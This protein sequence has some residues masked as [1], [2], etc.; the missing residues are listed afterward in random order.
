MIKH[1][2]KLFITLLF[3]QATFAAAQEEAEEISSLPELKAA[4]TQLIADRDVPA[5]AIAMVDENGP[6]WVGAIGKANLQ[7]NI[8][9]DENTLFRIGSTSKMF[10]SLS[11]LKLVE[12][13]KLSLNDK[14]SALAPEI[15]YK[16]Q[17]ESTDPVRVVHLLE[18]TTG[19]DDIHLPEYAHNDPTPITLKQGLD[20][21]PHS[22]VSRWAPGSRMTYCNSG[23]AVAAY[24]VQKLTGRD[25]EEYVNESF[26]KPLGM[27]TATYVLSENVKTNGA[28]LYA[29]GNQPQDYWHILIRPSG[30]INASAKDMA[31]FLTFFIDRGAVSGR[32]LISTESLKRMETVESTSGAKVGLQSGYGLSNYSSEHENWVYRAHNG[33]VNGGITDFA[34]LP[35]A[36]LGHAV[37]INSDDGSTYRDISK[38]ISEYETRNLTTDIS[39]DVKPITVAHKNI[40]GLYYPINSRQQASFFLDRILGVQKLWIEENKLA[41]QSLLGGDIKYYFPASEVLYKSAKTGAVSLVRAVDPLDGEVIHADSA[42]LKPVSA[43]LMYTQLGVVVLWGLSIVTSIIYT[44]VWVV[45]KMRGKIPTGV[46]IRI[47]L[48]PLL[49]SISVIAMIFLLSF[50]IADPFQLLGAPSAISIGIMLSTIAFAYF[51]ALGVYTSVRE[52]RTEMNRGNYWYSTISSFVHFT[53]AVYLFYYGVVG[54]MTW[55]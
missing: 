41:R 50:G 30:A 32:Q 11:I 8:D 31:K 54:L 46:A 51:A 38:L 44:L 29:N 21:H 16:N 17:W 35:E 15:E 23:P 49:A 40:E 34:Y 6:V 52:R 2:T 42:V 28:T 3:L 19:W 36:K 26:F 12:E 43:W 7:D 14:L 25:F 4:I 47:R 24:I 18:H 22:R 45:R 48:W 9:A 5:A 20:Y 55:A 1:A 39:S 13:G 37:M 33:G 53:V 27:D 10:V